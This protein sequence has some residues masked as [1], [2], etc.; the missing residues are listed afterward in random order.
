VHP[1]DRTARVRELAR[2]MSGETITAAAL[3]SAEQLLDFSRK[4]T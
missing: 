3:E 2:I 1:L 4:T